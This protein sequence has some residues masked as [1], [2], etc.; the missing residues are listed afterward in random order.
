M[1]GVTS[2]GAKIDGFHIPLRRGFSWIR[3]PDEFIGRQWTD[4][5]VGRYV[6]DLRASLRSRVSANSPA[7]SFSMTLAGVDT[8][9]V[10]FNGLYKSA[11]L[12]GSTK[13]MDYRHSLRF[14]PDGSVAQGYAVNHDG[15]RLAW[16]PDAPS[17]TPNPHVPQ[18]RL[19]LRGTALSVDLFRTDGVFEARYEGEI[20]SGRL[21]LRCD[22]PDSRFAH[23]TLPYRFHPFDPNALRRFYG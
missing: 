11:R 16:E 8:S 18:G 5:G 9:E 14:Y 23:E 13:V 17:P 20:K 19:L 7:H 3:L 15:R 1:T 22:C 10:A 6:A 2:K 4:P 12:P 21:W